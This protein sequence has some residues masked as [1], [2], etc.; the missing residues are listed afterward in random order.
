MRQHF[1]SLGRTKAVIA[2]TFITLVFALLCTLITEFTLNQ[3]GAEVDILKGVVV[4][5]CV[6]LMVAPIMSWFIVRVFFEMHHIE[7]EIRTL[8]TYDSLTGLL[9][10]REFLE[11]AEYLYQVAK[12]EGSEFSFVVVDIDNFKS[13]NDQYG[14]IAGDKVL[15]SFGE[16]VRNTFRES[17]LSC[18]FGGDEFV[19]FLPN[20]SSEEA[21]LFTE[22][23]HAKIKDAVEVDR[24]RIEYTASIGVATYPDVASYHIDD[25]IK[26]ADRALYHAKNMGRNQTQVI[27]INHRKQ[28]FGN[29]LQQ[30]LL[31]HQPQSLQSP[32]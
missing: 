31:S 16:V 7:E 12:R 5:T 13:I 8:A 28:L 6:S 27:R 9:C 23:L 2:L 14:H 22:R 30:S 20:T 3:L 24:G 21:Q 32:N 10:R 29:Q 17:D 26:A 4:A 1:F 19:F 15:E 11:R 25:V 18:R